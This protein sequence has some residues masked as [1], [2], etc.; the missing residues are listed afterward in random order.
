MD[1]SFLP[2]SIIAVAAGFAAGQP[3]LDFF[4]EQ[5]EEADC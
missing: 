1:R 3:F 5:H 2:G 4:V